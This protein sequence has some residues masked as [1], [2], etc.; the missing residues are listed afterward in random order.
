MNNNFKWTR[1]LRY[2]AYQAWPQEYQTLLKEQVAHSP[3]RL[4]YHIQPPSGLLNDPNG[5]FFFQRQ[6]ALIL[7][8][9]S[10]GHC[11]WAKILVPLDFEEFSRLARGRIETSTQHII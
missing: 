11:S 2:Q 6:M 5:F 1:Q 10:D 9:L 7:P 8:S 3:W 4:D